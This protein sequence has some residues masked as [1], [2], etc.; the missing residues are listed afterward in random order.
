MA[1][2]EK[3]Q[4]AIMLIISKDA[5]LTAL[6]VINSIFPGLVIEIPASIV[7]EVPK[8]LEKEWQAELDANITKQ[9]QHFGGVYTG[10]SYP[11]ELYWSGQSDEDEAEAVAEVI[12]DEELHRDEY[13]PSEETSDVTCGNCGFPYDVGGGVGGICTTCYKRFCEECTPSAFVVCSQCNKKVCFDCADQTAFQC[14]F[15]RGG[16]KFLYAGENLPD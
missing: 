11:N 7:E 3:Y 8:E 12:V 14:E 4:W 2:Y 1:R 13:T 10:G 16:G 6:L 9:Y 5:K 15:C